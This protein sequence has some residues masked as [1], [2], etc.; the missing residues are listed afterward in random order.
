MNDLVDE[1]IEA[2]AMW[3]KHPGSRDAVITRERHVALVAAQ[4]DIPAATLH[5][6]ITAGRRTGYGP[7][8]AVL[9]AITQAAAA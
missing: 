7:Q 9:R 3:D 1:L 2:W 5:D 4:L 8:Q 6:T